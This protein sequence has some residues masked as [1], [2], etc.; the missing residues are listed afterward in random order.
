MAVVLTAHTVDTTNVRGVN[1]V[2]QLTIDEIE[3]LFKFVETA[4]KTINYPFDHRISG[5][6][7]REF[8]ILQ[9]L[10]GN[11]QILLKQKRLNHDQS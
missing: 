2:E 11:Y 10:N 3:E 1:K 9:K 5:R 8:H 6:D 7:T 4:S